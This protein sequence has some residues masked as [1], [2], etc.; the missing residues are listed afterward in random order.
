MGR[1]GRHT[2]SD[3]RS[4]TN[5]SAHVKNRR[6]MIRLPEFEEFRRPVSG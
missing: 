6:P 3:P 5:S 1:Y 2:L 4:L